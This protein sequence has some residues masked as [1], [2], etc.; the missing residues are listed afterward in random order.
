M[1]PVGRIPETTRRGTFWGAGR[2][3][4]AAASVI[5]R[6]PRRLTPR[7]LRSRAPYPKCP[8]G[9]LGDVAAPAQRVD[10]GPPG[11]LAGRCLLAVGTMDL[12]D[13]AQL[14]GKLPG[15]RHGPRDGLR[16]LVGGVPGG[17]VRLDREQ[18]GQ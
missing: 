13:D 16:R 5:A 7:N 3:A 10:G 12:F 9:S 17:F 18:L 15:R 4:C 8:V 14:P 1:R 2:L 11:R 6:C